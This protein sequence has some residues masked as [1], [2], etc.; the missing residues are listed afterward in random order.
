MY[1]TDIDLN[2]KTSFITIVDSGGHIVK[3]SYLCNDKPIIFEY[4]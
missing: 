3:K 1:Y 4:S 2:R